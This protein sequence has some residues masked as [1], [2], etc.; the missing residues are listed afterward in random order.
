[1]MR[2]KDSIMR[3]PS[4]VRVMASWLECRS[5]MSTPSS[6]SAC[7]T[8]LETDDCE[9]GIISAAAEKLPVTDTV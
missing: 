7:F 1:M 5:K 8:L 9:H 6:S 2:T 3:L 4:A